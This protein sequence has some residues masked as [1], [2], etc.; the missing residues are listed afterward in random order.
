MKNIQ[1][2]ERESG[3]DEKCDESR[4]KR[5]E[6]SGMGRGSGIRRKGGRK[7][8]QERD[9]GLYDRGI[10]RV[11]GGG[12]GSVWVNLLTRDCGSGSKDPRKIGGGI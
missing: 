11:I 7:K 1:K 8:G 4:G 2:S 12:E 5:G 3:I 10:D 9:W 6:K